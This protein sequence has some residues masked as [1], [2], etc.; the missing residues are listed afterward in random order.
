M[1]S[2]NPKITKI[3][4]IV[5]YDVSNNNKQ[6]NANVLKSKSEYNPNGTITEAS[7][8]YLSRDK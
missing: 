8:N 1:L 7:D 4:K 2:Q 5:T 3:I 6:I